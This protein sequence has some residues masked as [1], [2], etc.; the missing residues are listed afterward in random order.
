M[1]DFKLSAEQQKVVDTRNASLL[2]AAAA[3]SGKTA[4]L[5][6]RIMERIKEGSVSVDRLLIVT[7]TRLAASEMLERL[8][9]AL[10]KE[11]SQ[12]PLDQKLNMQYAKL[13]N[14]E[15]STID[16]FCG[17]IVKENF[18]L[19]DINPD[20]S[21]MEE[22]VEK[23]LVDDI[24]DDIFEEEYTAAS[25][26][27]ICLVRSYGTYRDDKDVRNYIKNVLKKAENEPWPKKWLND[28]R[29]ECDKGLPDELYD[30]IAAETHELIEETYAAIKEIKEGFM[31]CGADKHAERVMTDLTNLEALR[32]LRPDF[33]T[34]FKKIKFEFANFNGCRYNGKS[35]ADHPVDITQKDLLANRRAKFK[36]AFKN[37]ISEFYAFDRAENNIIFK[38]T[39]PAVKKLIELTIELKNRLWETKKE[40][41][42]FSFSDIEHMALDILCTEDENGCVN[43]TETAREISKEYDEIMIDEYQDSSFIQEY[44]LASVSHDRSVVKEEGTATGFAPNLFMVGDVKQSIYRFRNASPELFMGKY[45]DFRDAGDHIK[46]DL[47]KNYRSRESVLNSINVLLAPIMRE[48]LT[49]IEYDSASALHFGSQKSYCPDETQNPNYNTELILIETNPKIRKKLNDDTSDERDKQNPEFEAEQDAE[50][51]D[52]EGE[53]TEGTEE[54]NDSKEYIAALTV[55]R[56]IREMVKNGFPVSAGTD[57]DNKPITRN[58]KYGDFALLFLYTTGVSKIYTD[59]FQK[60]GIPISS[61][62]TVGFFDTVEIKKMMSFLKILDN[63]YD[64]ISF[65]AILYSEIVNIDAND[66]GIIAAYK[67]SDNENKLPLYRAAR[68]LCEK[69][70]NQ[71]KAESVDESKTCEYYEIVKMAEAKGVIKKLKRFFALYDLLLAKR[72]TY[73]VHSL[74]E[75]IYDETGYKDI[76]SVMPYGER[77]RGNL[78]LLVSL[79]KRFE[80]GAYAGVH[81]FIHYIDRCIENEEKF[82]EASPEKTDDAVRILTIHKSK[83]LEFPVVFLCNTDKEFNKNDFSAPIIMNHKLGI[84]S[85]YVDTEKH[86]KYKTLKQNVILGI[87]KSKYVSE[88]ARVLYVALTRAKEKLFIV[89]KEK[90]LPGKK[91]NKNKVEKWSETVLSNDGAFLDCDIAKVNRLMDFVCPSL[92]VGQNIDIAELPQKDITERIRITR[93]C[94]TE[95]FSA[96]FDVTIAAYAASDAAFMLK[97]SGYTREELKEQTAKHRENAEKTEKTNVLSS[98][99]ECQEKEEFVK[100]RAELPENGDVFGPGTI[101]DNPDILA[102]IKAQ[103][104]FVY[105]YM[106]EAFA[107]VRVSVSELKHIEIENLLEESEKDAEN[108]PY[109]PGFLGGEGAEQFKENISDLSISD[110]NLPK[111]NVSDTCAD[112]NTEKSRRFKHENEVQKGALR[113]TLYHEVFEKLQYNGKYDTFED[114]KKSVSEDIAYLI[115]EGFLEDDILDTVSIDKIAKFCMSDIGKRMIMAEQT[116]RLH[117]EQPFVYNLTPS[118]YN[119]YSKTDKAVTPVMVQGIIDAYIDDG[120]SI[121]IIDYKTDRI[122]KDAESELRA[123]YHVQLDIYA[124]AVTKITGKRVKEKIIYS[125]AKDT[126]FAV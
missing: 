18:D 95:E 107:P 93:N 82:G 75:A 77:R 65:A 109:L 79:A 104:E 113:G 17:R 31:A 44:I 71:K 58:V 111:L 29:E 59:V 83:G 119:F 89:G 90:L 62:I 10:E 98:A 42:G 106:A 15:I 120:D 2:V 20:F 103:K 121:T 76:V 14:A 94:G 88:E 118:E 8:E 85:N 114:A 117:R 39:V 37:Y 5:V 56:K 25:P 47:S 27:F 45:H 53:D 123:K 86:I 57:S 12:N 91:E 21:V 9:S 13:K 46:I 74:I 78:A 30:K 7:F 70:E 96:D 125:V 11:I 55:G 101:F 36:D 3:G 50:G 61:E 69:A 87:E 40:K 35:Y 100:S 99:N 34:Y 49:E 4:V 51:E 84:A 102:E 26:D 73:T 19:C 115:K 112:A 92:L 105:P 80:H 52:T 64:D 81:D 24:L 68:E 43:R 23:Q 16:S 41:N 32:Q 116:G 97:N 28:I 6:K 108:V 1:A 60:M 54:E 63:P 110:L 67:N 48:S 124:L 126:D 33:D 38:K 122:N 66:L 22:T 72:N